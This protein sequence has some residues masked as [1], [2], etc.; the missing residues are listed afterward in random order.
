VALPNVKKGT[1]YDIQVT[2]NFLPSEFAFQEDLP[3]LHSELYLETSP[4]I[5]FRKRK[6]GFLPIQSDGRNKYYC[7]NM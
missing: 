3:V 4:Y 1:V 6:V 2:H 7:D 5:E